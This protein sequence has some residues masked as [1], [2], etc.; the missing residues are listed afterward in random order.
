MIPASL[1]DQWVGALDRCLRTLTNH[2]ECRGQP[3][4]AHAVPEG[5]L[6]AAQRRHAAGLM[7]V[8]HTGEICAQALY[9]GQAFFERNDALKATF[10]HAAIEEG[11]HLAWCQQ[12]LHELDSRHSYL[13]PV[14]YLGSFCIGSFASVIGGSWNLGFM[15]ET[16][17]QVLRHLQKHCAL[18]PSQ[19]QRSYVL[20]KA[21]AADEARHQHTAHVHGAR[22]LPIWVQTAMQLTSTIMVRLAYW[23]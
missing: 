13:A 23:I 7:R 1:C 4:P 15:E 17:N 8:N 6:T 21:I 22:T 3:Y 2:P 19:D 9:H 20:L 14:W 12:R 5:Q 11:D 10:Y 18:L 16:E